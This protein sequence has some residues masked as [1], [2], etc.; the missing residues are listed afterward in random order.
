MFDTKRKEYNSIFLAD[1]YITRDRCN[2]YLKK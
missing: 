1:I 2:N